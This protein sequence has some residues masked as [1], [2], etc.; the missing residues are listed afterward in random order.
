[1]SKVPTRDDIIRGIHENCKQSGTPMT[2]AMAEMM[3]DQI[4]S[5]SSGWHLPVGLPSIKPA[6]EEELR[7]QAQ[8]Y[9]EKH[10]KQAI[11]PYWPIDFS[12][13]ENKKTYR[14]PVDKNGNYPPSN[15][16][17]NKKGEAIIGSDGTWMTEFDPNKPCDHKW[18]SYDGFNDRFDYCTVCDAKRR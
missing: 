1:M 15:V 10:H 7:Q 5:Q 17:K 16:Y 6:T 11:S 3:A 8:D 2:D 9:Y 14:S 13:E 4:I 18:T 12:D